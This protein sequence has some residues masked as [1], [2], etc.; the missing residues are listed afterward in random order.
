MWREQS[1]KE[2]AY[3]CMYRY[4]D[5]CVQIIVF[6]KIHNPHAHSQHAIH[7]EVQFGLFCGLEPCDP[8]RSPGSMQLATAV[9]SNSA[10]QM[11]TNRIDQRESMPET[12]TVWMA[13]TMGT[14]F[15][16][17]LF[18]RENMRINHWISGVFR[19]FSPNMLSRICK[20]YIYIWWN[21]NPWFP[22][23]GLQ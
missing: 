9:A 20:Y 13:L 15:H 21:K 10:R 6:A 12:S 16:L 4:T 22:R 14:A 5:R 8:E 17:H 7:L 18:F 11:E 2:Y 19:S 3:L 1:G 23:D